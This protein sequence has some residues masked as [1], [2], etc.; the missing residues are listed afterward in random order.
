[1]TSFSQTQIDSKKNRNRSL[2]SFRLRP[3]EIHTFIHSNECERERE[4]GRRTTTGGDVFA[5]TKAER[6]EKHRATALGEVYNM[7]SL[8]EKASK[9][10][11]QIPQRDSFTEES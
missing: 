3:A 10:E 6:K 9:F 11:S 4:R 1:M 2:P 8:M 7:L 5:R